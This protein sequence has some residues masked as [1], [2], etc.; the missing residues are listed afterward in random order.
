MLF[1]AD[2]KEL[3]PLKMLDGGGLEKAPLAQYVRRGWH[4]KAEFTENA[5][6]SFFNQRFNIFASTQY[7][8]RDWH[9]KALFTENARRD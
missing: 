6:K 3:F 5:R 9:G 8:R 4:E 2:T 1:G 7:F